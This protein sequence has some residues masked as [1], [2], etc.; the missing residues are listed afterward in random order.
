MKVYTGIIIV[1][2]SFHSYA[3]KHEFKTFW[4]APVQFGVGYGYRIDHDWS[5]QLQVGVISEPNSGMILSI[6]EGLG[7][8]P[9]T[10]EM[11][12]NAF[13]FG[14]VVEL[15]SYYHFNKWYSGVYFHGIF[16]KGNEA[17]QEIVEE[18]METDIQSFPTKIGR[19]ASQITELE[20]QSDLYQ[21]GI[22]VGRYLNIPETHSGLYL[23]F[24][25]S[26]NLTSSSSLSSP[27][28]ELAS[29][30]E[31]VDD[32]LDGI[33]RTYAFIPSF[34]VGWVFRL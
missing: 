17:P 22:L 18:V 14:T 12:E 16:L 21:G 8:D 23:E 31:E 19:R 20:L 7:T 1:F 15:G 30:S 9:A 32:Y 13:K 2:I 4:E 3:Q 11:I 10:V 28:R 27:E 34:N 24:G 29:L 25:I 5:A 6:I 26:M 33:Y